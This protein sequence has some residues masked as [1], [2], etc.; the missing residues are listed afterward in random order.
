LLAFS[1]DRTRKVHVYDRESD[2]VVRSLPGNDNQGFQQVAWH[3]DGRSLAA[4]CRDHLLYLWNAET[5]ERI[6]TL[7][8]HW[9]E[10]MN[11]SFAPGGSLVASGGWDPAVRF[12]ESGSGRPLFSLPEREGYFAFT[13]NHR[14]W[15]VLATRAEIW[16]LASD[17]P[18]FTLLGHDR[19]ASSGQTAKHPRCIA[20]A[21]GGQLAATA[22]DDGV[23]LW[24]LAARAEVARLP[25]TRV[26]TVLFD[27]AGTALY[28]VGGRGLYRWPV[29]TMA[30][31][32]RRIAI[33][34]AQRLTQLD[35]LERAALAADDSR[36]AVIHQKS[37]AHVFAPSQP[38]QELQLQGLPADWSIALSPD[39]EWAAAGTWGRDHGQE[40]WIWRLSDPGAPG[41]ADAGRPLEPVRRLRAPRAEVRFHPG[42]AHLATCTPQ[43]LA[44][45]RL[46]DGEVVWR[47]EREP[48]LRFP[49]QVAFDRGGKLA[50]FTY[51]PSRI[52]LIDA[53]GGRKLAD[54]EAPEPILITSLAIEGGIV[55]AA[56]PARRFHVWDLNALGREIAG[57]GM[58]WEVPVTGKPL[59]EQAP[60]HVVRVDETLDLLLDETTDLAPRQL[61]RPTQHA[62]FLP[63]LASCAQIDQ[64]LARPGLLIS[65]EE[66]WRFFR[67]R[68]EPSPGLEWTGIDHDDQRWEEGSVPI[69]GWEAPE[70]PAATR[71]VDQL[72][73]YTTLY[74]RRAFDVPDPAR[75]SRL[76]LAAE[77]EDGFVVHL[78]GVEVGR[79]NA[80]KRGARLP[81]QALAPRQDR[82]RLTEV[83]EIDPSILRQ[84]KNVLAIQ[85]LS[86]GLDSRLHLLPVLAAVPAPQAERDRDRTDHLLAR[87]DGSPEPSL[88]AYR[89]GRILQ[90]GG[91]HAEALARFEKAG[92]LDRGAAEPLLRRLACHRALGEHAH[93]ETLA[94][95]AIERG[96][97]PETSRLWRAWHH[98]AL[99]D[100]H[101]SPAEAL[102][103]WPRDTGQELAGPASDH[104]AILEELAAGRAIRIHCGG[105]EVEARDGK[106]WLRDRFHVGGVVVERGTVHP[107][108]ALS[109]SGGEALE[110]PVGPGHRERAFPGTTRFRPGYSLPLP[111]GRYRITL[112]FVEWIHMLPGK[113]VFDVLLEGRTVIESCNPLRLGSAPFAGRKL[114][115]DV[116]DGAL[117]LD[118]IA[119]QDQPRIAAIE[120]ELLAE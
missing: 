78:N 85:A 51:T 22:G 36:I 2:R 90:R 13:A 74:A 35:A 115:V 10:V 39:G 15:S 21:P 14:C 68:A 101:R 111:P 105:D 58:S 30:E 49:G 87:A 113:R 117:D 100:L 119:H 45:W 118:F 44:L 70:E 34:P 114:E 120:V 89:D 94:R 57:L 40:V 46:A 86:Y 112:H 72:G 48:G 17:L 9:A 16:E 65:E 12:W 8:G 63:R 53:L 83:V 71:L 42:G 18:S 103:S 67:G 98:L 59:E 3:P 69:T 84:G 5:G 102:A 7:N 52:W 19:L 91:R 38:G 80:G 27:K 33:G 76:V 62:A 31:G 61:F 64:T 11:V 92:D 54:L 47:V 66:T 24:D 26:H 107:H 29:R 109:S 93:A 88:L 60:L 55:A 99:V 97:I 25:E 73:A 110:T 96:V 20:L 50:A 104:R 37:H 23:R 32:D 82:Q 77:L 75:V 4:A 6:R 95:E 106:R 108:A 79:V 56:V 1:S 41:P 81:F 116:R 43:D 28:S